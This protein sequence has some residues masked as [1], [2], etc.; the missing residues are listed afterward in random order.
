MVV[1][2]A[3]AAIRIQK[4]D[5]R[6]LLADPPAAT[7]REA[8]EGLVTRVQEIAQAAPPLDA[9]ALIATAKAQT[10]LSDFGDPT[11][12]QRFRLAVDHLNTVGLDAAGAQAAIDACLWQLT[13]RLEFFEDRKTHPIAEERIERPIFATGEPRSGTTL[14][15]ALLS[16]D[17]NGRTLRF[18]EVMYPSPPPGV[19]PPG[20]DR[21]ERAD[22]LWR[23][24]LKEMPQWLISHPYN[25]MLGDGIPEC[26]R[27][28]AWDFRV[29]TPAVWWR[30]P[31][32][33]VISGLPTD[34]VQ[35]YALHKMMLQHLQYG[36][37]KK[38]WVLK[39]F[40]GARLKP[41]FA[42]YPDARM[43]WTHRDPVQVTASKVAMTVALTEDIGG[44]LDMPSVV[45]TQINSTRAII[46]TVMNDPLATDPRIHHVRYQDVVADPVGVLR[47]FYDACDIPFD[48]ATEQA[49]RDYLLNNRSDRYGKFE[50]STDVLGDLAS[51]HAEFEPYRSRFGID[52][53][54]RG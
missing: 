23:D 25:D 27:T 38:R 18:W 39:G 29:M 51:L 41:M 34:P 45:E 20:D 8:V 49:A 3:S 16:V 54:Q 21:R 42:A 14:L 17:P 47:G 31:M 19:A 36:R 4:G 7:K 24:I 13:T 15:H 5:L 52:I 50:Y 28:W 6:R 1:P 40:H 9:E 46:R 11:L 33:P 37:E 43:I 26:E 12:P 32:A 30:V 2:A 53:E 48:A 22:S 35:Q 44:R 10:G